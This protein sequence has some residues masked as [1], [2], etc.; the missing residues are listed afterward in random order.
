MGKRVLVVGGVAGG[1]SA[2]ARIRRLDA[3]ASI[4]IFERGEHVS[5]SNCALPYFLSRT[6]EESD[7]LVLMTPESFKASYDIE[8]RTGH[9]VQAIDRAGKTIRVKNLATGEEYQEAYDE[10]VL[11][12]GS[13]PIRPRSIEGVF[14]PH[15]FTVRNVTDIVKLDQY[16]RR[17]GSSNV[18]VVGGG[19]IGLEVAENLKEAGK[20]VSVVEAASQ[21]MAPFDPDM[22][23][24]LHRELHD[25]GVKLYLGDGV[26]AITEEKVV[27][28]SGRELP[29]DVVVLAIG[30]VPETGLAKDAGLTIGEV[31]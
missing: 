18:V 27:L 29:A 7:Y 5:F 4:T 15:V 21:V 20:Q 13:S 11:S 14:L 26:K 19:F 8:V 17:E 31:F 9:E 28:G 1:A 3:E 25:Q 24:M 16:V 23:Q 22:V 10:L 12:P 6:V 30:V 2:A